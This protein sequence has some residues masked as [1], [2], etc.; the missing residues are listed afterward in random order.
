[1]TTPNPDSSQRDYSFI[2]P[3]KFA[4]KPEQTAASFFDEEPWWRTVL[5]RSWKGIYRDTRKAGLTEAEARQLT[6]RL[7]R[8]AAR[9]LAH[10]PQQPAIFKRWL[11]RIARVL[12]AHKFQAKRPERKPGPCDVSIAWRQKYIEHNDAS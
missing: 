5:A 4:S 6:T 10:R 1:M 7:L 12:I 11:L 2:A 8:N 3:Y 9:G